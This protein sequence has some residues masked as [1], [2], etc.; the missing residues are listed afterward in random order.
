MNIKSHFIIFLCLACLLAGIFQMVFGLQTSVSARQGRESPTAPSQVG[1]TLTAPGTPG[2]AAD[3]AV[4]DP[5]DLP[6]HTER[7]TAEIQLDVVPLQPAAGELPIPPGVAAPA[8]SSISQVGTA[9]R[10]PLS[11][12]PSSSFLALMDNLTRVPPDTMGAVGPNHLLI[13]LNTQVHVQNKSGVGQPPYP[14]GLSTFWNPVAPPGGWSSNGPFDPRAHY[15]PYG[16]RFIHV[17]LS[18]AQH[19]N[20]SI[21]VGV[22]QTNDPTGAWNLWRVDADPGNTLWADY[23]NLGFNKDWI[24]VSINLYTMANNFQRTDIYV[25]DKAN[26]YSNTTCNFTILQ[27]GSLGLGGDTYVPA[28]TYDPTLAR[29]YLVKDW[30][31]DDPGNN[32]GWLALLDISGP[33]GAEVLTFL[34]WIAT[35]TGVR[36]ERFPGVGWADFA[37]QLGS[38]QRIMNNDSRIQNVVYRNGSVWSTHTIFLPFDGTGGSVA[39]RSS[40]QWWEIGAI[41]PY[42]IVQLG[43]LDDPTGNTFYAFPSIAANQLS[44]VLVG[45]SRFSAAQYASGNYAYHDHTDPPSSLQADTVLKAGEAPYYKIGSGTLNRWGDFSHTVVDPANDTDLWTIQQYAAQ[46]TAGVDRWSTWWGRVVPPVLATQ[47]PTPTSTPIDTSTP[48]LTLTP[49]PTTPV[50]TQTATPTITLT[51]TSLTPGATHTPTRSPTPTLTATSATL[52][53]TLTETGASDT[54]TSTGTQVPTAT[55][56]PT[57]TQPPSFEIYLPILLRNVSP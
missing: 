14:V 5:N 45:Y 39:T 3:H 53:P 48:T 13:T 24:V 49:T 54:P 29:V 52:T 35:P 37:P 28:A 8:A 27:P 30:N 21:L 12:P 57:A 33:V 22:T 20:S 10:S 25:F 51:P 34:S 23:P 1:A 11:P 46:P 40:V 47:T 44:D 15:D 19:A 4:F 26:L 56:T 31:G 55:L 38:A 41:S 2:A 16:G 17:A 42:P 43:R 7:P 6:R 32:V 36:W 9:S 50:T 18:D